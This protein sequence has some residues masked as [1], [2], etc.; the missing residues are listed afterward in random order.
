MEDLTGRNSLLLIFGVLWILA[1]AGH[2]WWLRKNRFSRPPW[3]LWLIA[4]G[5]LI[6]GELEAKRAGD[7]QH[8][9]VQHLTEDFARLYGSEM[10][11][12]GHWKLP[13]NAP[14]SDPLFLTLIEKE[15]M[16]EKLNPDVADIYT[17]RKRPDGTNIFI[18]DSE[19]DYDRNGKYEGEREQRT[20]IG[21]VYDKF[22]Q[23]L[24]DALAGKAN[25]DLVPVTDRWGTWI[26]AF[27][28]MYNPSG[29]LDG[30][31]GVDFD[32][33]QFERAIANAQLRVLAIVAVLLLILLAS[34]VLNTILRAQIEERRKTEEKLRLLGSAVE[35]SQE[36]ILVTDAQLDQPGPKIVF[37]NPAFTKMTG[38]TREEALGKTP[39]ILQGPRTD[40][41]VT[42]N[43]RATL[44]RG[45]AAHGET[46]NYRKDRTEFDV[47]WDIA[48]IRNSKQ[49]ITHFVGIQRDVSQRKRIEQQLIQSQKLETVGKLAGGVAHEFNNIMMAIIGHADLMLNN[50]PENNALTTNAKVIRQAAERA[51]ILTRQLRAYAGRQFLRPQSLDLNE[52]I[53]EM[54][55]LIGHLVGVEINVS[56]VPAADLCNV[57]AD[58]GQISEVITNIVLNAKDAMPGGGKLTIETGNMSF[59]YETASRYPGLK[60]GNYASLSITDTGVGMKPEVQAR[61]FEPF[62]TTKGVGKGT[63]LGLATA[64]GIIKQSG[65]HILVYSEIGKGTTF[66]IYLPE[67]QK[68]PRQ[69][70]QPTQPSGAPSGSEIILVVED[71]DTVREMTIKFLRQLGYNVLSATNG[72]EALKLLE[73]P[74]REPVDLLFTDIVM[75]VMDGMEL[76]RRVA[77]SHPGMKVLFASAYAENAL[78]HQGVVEPG[79]T[80]LEKPFSL[81]TLAQKV[82]KALES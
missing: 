44:A 66:R 52:V 20:D 81:S 51:S 49:V 47:E 31:L 63:G 1:F 72:E 62:F 28:P 5:L 59:D 7:Q 27:V 3:I 25:F 18:V 82:R 8:E 40:K 35:Q 13:D 32:A 16:W 56:I 34:S 30:V 36:A 46:V 78:I 80:L 23:G 61:M 67:L 38:Y 45:E 43:L 37:V 29:K 76:S 11:E 10:E 54:E 39:R 73:T 42:Y 57:L 4:L 69:K 50:I 19:T 14:A 64:Y 24:E 74:G 26:S 55:I 9:N 79:M 12:S 33:I 70:V 77:K 2:Y 65:G 68:D 41:A 17:L 75:P 15:K 71:D 58:P 6:Y 22:D 21:E 48:P 53:S 60:P